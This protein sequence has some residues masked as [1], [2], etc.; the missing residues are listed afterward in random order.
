VAGYIQIYT[1]K[2]KGKTTAAMGLAI[3]AV[4]AGLSVYIGQFVKAGLYSEHMV[5][6]NYL[7]MIDIETYGRNCFIMGSPDKIDIELAQEGWQKSKHIII[8]NKYDIV[9]LDE[10]NVAIYY[11]LIDKKDVMFALKNKPL[12]MEIILTGRY[13]DPDLIDLADLVTEM[14]EIKHYYKNNVQARDGI[15]R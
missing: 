9:I 11:S 2:G 8:D 4:G 1:G 6:K 12:N 7:T 15:E 13:A 14:K 3:R 10:I 5:F